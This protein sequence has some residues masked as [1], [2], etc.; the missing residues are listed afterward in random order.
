[1]IR[2]I[3]TGAILIICALWFL[4]MAGGYGLVMWTLGLAS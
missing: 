1:M 4:A 3:V 2:K